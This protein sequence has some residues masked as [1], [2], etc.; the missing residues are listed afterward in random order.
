[1]RWQWQRGEVIVTIDTVKSSGRRRSG[2]FRALSIGVASVLAT[3]GLG[4]A[5]VP[6]SAGGSPMTFT[7][8]TPVTGP[9]IGG[10][11]FTIVGTN[12]TSASTVT[13][14][15]AAATGLSE[16]AGTSITGTTPAGAVGAADVVITDPT[17]GSV[18]GAGAFTYS[19]VNL[20]A[21]TVVAG[22]PLTVSGVTIPGASVTVTFD[23]LSGS[24][25]ADAVTG[26]Y[27]VALTPLKATTAGYLNSQVV[28]KANGDTISTP[29]DVVTVTQALTGASQLVRG[30]G[31]CSNTPYCLD[32]SLTAGTGYDLITLIGSGL[33][34]YNSVNN[35]DFVG[36]VGAGNPSL[37]SLTGPYVTF[38]N[39][40]GV[41]YVAAW[42]WAGQIG[43]NWVLYAVSGGAVGAAQTAP[44]TGTYVL[45]PFND[46]AI[47]GSTSVT[48]DSLTSEGFSPMSGP[49]T[50]GTP[51]DI[52]IA[53]SYTVTGVTIGG[54]AVSS[55]TATVSATSPTITSVTG[56]TAPATAG[57]D[58]VVITYTSGSFTLPSVFTYVGFASITPSSGPTWAPQGVVILGGGFTGST[59]ATV[60]GNAMSGFQVVSD[61]EITGFVPQGALGP[62]D[63][64]ILNPN[65]N[66][67]GLGAYTYLSV[68]LGGGGGGGGSPQA[69][70]P[71]VITSTSG[72]A[73]SP[74]TLTTSGGSGTGA[75]SYVVTS[76]GTAGCS[77]TGTVLSATSA[78]TC[79]VTATKASDATYSVIS[80]AP[81]TITL[82][83]ALTA[84]APLV[85][86]STSGTAGTPLTLTTSGGSGT[87]AVSYVV[88]SAGGA[89]CSITG[90]VLSATG[91][92]TCT[93]TAT[94]ASDGTYSAVSSAPTAI[95]LAAATPP[96]PVRKR[97]H[98]RAIR[99]NGFVWVGR[100]STVTIT[101][102]GFYAQPTIT[103]NEPGTRAGVAHDNG[104][105]LVVR[106]SL[107][108][109]SPKGWHT[110]T[111]TLAN[112]TWC[113]VNYLV[114]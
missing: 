9:T 66:L 13:I 90:D 63:V 55:F 29:A 36:T 84:Q 7:S 95:T 12:F 102:V 4:L 45:T 8:I 31:T 110:F 18:T 40:S 86:T 75:V 85:I 25:T 32:P 88:T 1:M 41:A 2:L 82:A 11:A 98:V 96:P 70:A 60:G 107:Q 53:G 34:N 19:T 106:V 65:G 42:V 33:T 17:N 92:G 67:V 56:V 57:L 35:S 104:S 48:F 23:H 24:D 99:V 76:A 46:P 114:K 83:A 49:N 39:A 16:T 38:S 27:S 59:G 78:G 108:A 91:A 93:V 54:V 28:V 94:K 26:D 47:T 100:M 79:T 68:P 5:A 20:S 22:S 61:T 87:G 112:G 6:A 3:A 89:S 51:F 109:G 58:D 103:S 30:T 21:T 50:G 97:P 80:S 44:I 37:A 101:G 72:T 81:T 73:G 52:S 74:L 14:G 69:Q 77:I 111:I 43:A 15:G 105:T 71:L 64:V 10:T 62:A 113:R